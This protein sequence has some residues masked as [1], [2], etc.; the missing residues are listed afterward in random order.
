MTGD[1]NNTGALY[2][3][4]VQSVSEWAEPGEHA[5]MV[6][7]CHYALIVVEMIQFTAA[8]IYF[9]PSISV[10]IDQCMWHVG[11]LYVR[12]KPTSLSYSPQGHNVTPAKVIHD[13]GRVMVFSD[14]SFM[15]V[16]MACGLYINRLLS[17]KFGG[18]K[19]NNEIE[20]KTVFTGS[21]PGFM[22]PRVCYTRANCILSIALNDTRVPS[23]CYFYVALVPCHTKNVAIRHFQSK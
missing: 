1:H 3:M 9:R 7:T 5:V 10:H 13:L 4:H 18:F 17:K 19:N 12:P 11:R 15:S 22:G 8:W 21:D 20:K 14:N 16:M 2:S 23:N 6:S